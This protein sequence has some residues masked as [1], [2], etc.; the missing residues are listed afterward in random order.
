MKKFLK[1]T[2]NVPDL[3]PRPCENKDTVVPA[4]D[5][6]P[7][8]HGGWCARDPWA[9]TTNDW[10]ER[11]WLL[12]QPPRYYMDY[13]SKSKVWKVIDRWTDLPAIPPRR[14]PRKAMKIFLTRFR[15]AAPTAKG[16]FRRLLKTLAV[17]CPARLKSRRKAFEALLRQH[18]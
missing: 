5:L 12:D 3:T 13:D 7:A 18:L 8:H 10:P 1:N 6:V 11:I 16:W 14:S 17:D 9:F 2:S 15:G 4:I